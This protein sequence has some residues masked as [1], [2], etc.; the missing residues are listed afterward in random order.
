MLEEAGGLSRVK[1][2]QPNV[3]EPFFEGAPPQ[4]TPGR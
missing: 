1:F 3:E 4:Q 2:H